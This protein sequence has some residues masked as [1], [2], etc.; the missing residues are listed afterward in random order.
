MHRCQMKRR[1]LGFARL[2]I[3]D[4]R[5][6][7]RLWEPPPR[8]TATGGRFHWRNR[9]E[10]LRIFKLKQ[11]F[12]VR[13]EEG[14]NLFVTLS[15][16]LCIIVSRSRHGGAEMKD[17]F[18]TFLGGGQ[19]SHISGGTHHGW[20]SCPPGR[21]RETFLGVGHEYRHPACAV[22]SSRTSEAREDLRCAPRAALPS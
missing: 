20:A 6:A 21:A 14:N 7:P 16:R 12:E 2:Y 1:V 10:T 17:P 11:R 3:N 19:K 22:A 4:G 15:G 5:N 18:T 13:K 8:T 9:S